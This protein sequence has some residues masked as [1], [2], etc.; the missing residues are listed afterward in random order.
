MYSY[1]K[2]VDPL[3]TAL[4]R[5]MPLA[6]G[7]LASFKSQLSKV[8]KVYAANGM[9]PFGAPKVATAAAPATRR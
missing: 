6:G 5:T 3:K 7:S 1:G 9:G 2:Y 4:P 8:E